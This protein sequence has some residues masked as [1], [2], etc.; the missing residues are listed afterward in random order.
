MAGLLL[1]PQSFGL[2]SDDQH[3]LKFLSDV[4]KLMIM[5]FAGMEID[6]KDFFKRW[7]ESLLLGV[8]TFA[9]P[10]GMG[11]GIS[12]AFGYSP[13]SSLLIGSLL[14]SHTLVALPILKKRKLLGQRAVGV[15]VGATIITDV[16]ALMVLA[17]VVSVH[18]V[19]LNGQ[20]LALRFLGLITYFPL[21]LLVTHFLIINFLPLLEKEGKEEQD[22]AF[23]LLMFAMLFAAVWAEMVHLEGI[24]GAFTAGLAI[25]GVVR[26]TALHTRMET[27][28]NTLFIPMF[29]LTTGAL[30]DPTSF[31]RMSGLDYLFTGL[32]VGGLFLAK[33]LAAFITGKILKF[34]RKDI[35]ISWSLSVPQVAATLAAALVAFETFNS[36]GERL[37]DDT[38]LDTV[39]IL[40]AVTVVAGPIM[41]KAFSKSVPSKEPSYSDD[42]EK[43]TR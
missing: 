17:I 34:S 28:G 22:G 14:A 8:L 12:V 35:L 18:T 2:V 19:G 1:G 29:F 25:G 6:L 15:T 7:N 31:A 33:L 40:M 13:L 4:G 37:I 24:V 27:I 10:L 5:F 20:E 16:S 26:G 42:V 21:V 43:T 32:I 3:I 11:Y 9:L 30:I 23:I 41:T 39:L 38:V 36:S